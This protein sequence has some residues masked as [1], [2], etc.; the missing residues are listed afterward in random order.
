MRLRFVENPEL[1]AGVVANLRAAAGWDGRKD[2][3][4]KIVGCTY[5]T[6]ACFD[7]EVLAGFVDV[8]SDGVEDAFIRNLVVHPAYRRRGVSL[9]LL[10][11]VVSRV[12][13]DGI[14]TTNVL[15]EPELEP[16]YRK[17]GFKVIMGGIID[18]EK[19]SR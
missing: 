12:R 7:G 14:K 3:M 19:V 15:F 17:A 5:M 1:E 8:I 11:I 4:E 10:R 13:A 2:K 6:V 18:N 16:L 9:N